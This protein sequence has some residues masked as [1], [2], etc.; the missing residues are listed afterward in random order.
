M[1]YS[2][3]KTIL[4]GV[5][6]MF[7]L[8][9]YSQIAE[10]IITEE[11]PAEQ[12]QQRGVSSGSEIEAIDGVTRKTLMNDRMVLEYPHINEGDVFWST[13]IWGVIDVREKI[14]QPF[15]YPTAPFFQLMV[16]GIQEGAIQP[17]MGDSDDFEEEMDMKAVNDILF[18]QDTV[19]VTNPETFEQ[20]A[21]VVHNDI[22]FSTINKFRI[23]EIWFFDK[24][25]SRMRVRILGICPIQD[26]TGED[27]S[28]AFE[29]PMFWIYWPQARKYFATQ[30]VH[31]PGNSST[32]LSWDDYM[33]MRYFNYYVIKESNI[34]DFRLEDYPSMAGNDREAKMKRMME[35]KKIK[36][37][38][39]NYENDLWSY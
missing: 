27:G 1:R 20:E 29:Y 14:N 11:T 36:E 39:F 6:M 13:Y 8:T 30:Q 19:F 25:H 2:I 18:Q 3:F 17:Y 21:Q 34:R 22:D 23:K 9:G 16:E 28:F 38:I 12:E 5:M 10:E 7:V 26:K 24:L 31:L 4:S 32:I 33:E 35:S 15:V 37:S